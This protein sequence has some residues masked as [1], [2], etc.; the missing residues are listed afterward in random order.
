MK[1]AVVLFNL[2]GPDSPEAVRPFLTNL[3]ND[4]AIMRVPSLLRRFLAWFI[5]WRR[6]EEAAKIYAQLGGASPILSE[7]TAQADALQDVL[8]ERGDF[9]VFV[10]MRHWHPLSE[11]A[12]REV[13]AYAPDKICLVP[14]YPQF[15]TTTTG[16]SLAAWYAAAKNVG[17]DAETRALCCYPVDNGFVNG[18]A[19]IVSAAVNRC[20][21]DSGG[22][23]PRVLFSAHG[24]P[25]KIVDAGDPYQWQ[26]EATTRAVAAAAGLAEGSWLVCYQSRVGPLQWIGPETEAE[27]KR[28]GSEKLPLVVVPIAFVSEHS[29]TLIELDVDYR[30]VAEAAGVPVYER[31][32]T[33]RTHPAFINGLADLVIATEQTG[34]ELQSAQGHRQCPD[35]MVCCA[36]TE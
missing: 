22:R 20:R 26:V 18:Q 31:A 33:V 23:E 11:A 9:R 14:L 12:A 21:A 6:S 29:E 5:A 3:F 2:G 30:H 35:S 7:T 32:G 19:E 36:L 34:R 1:T 25:Q 17:V 15:S 13:A 8:G 10:A 27:I 28:A 16:S 4:P 24:L